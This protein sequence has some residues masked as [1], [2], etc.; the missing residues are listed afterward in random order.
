MTTAPPHQHTEFAF[1]QQ[2]H[3]ANGST[4]PL[5]AM[6]LMRLHIFRRQ[7]HPYSMVHRF[8][9]HR[10][11]L[12]SRNANLIC[13][14][15]TKGPVSRTMLALVEPR[16]PAPTLICQRGTPG[17]TERNPMAR[18][19]HRKHSTRSC[20]MQVSAISKT[21]NWTTSA[22]RNAYNRGPTG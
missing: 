18:M 7:P 21:K 22:P 14:N 15:R 20:E 16:P 1:G 13:D 10:A 11:L 4:T 17:M 2:C 3:L 12:S 9:Y 8:G 6:A 5:K 19:L